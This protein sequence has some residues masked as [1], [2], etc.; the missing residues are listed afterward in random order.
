MGH[1][2]QSYFLIKTKN[3]KRILIT[4]AA[5]VALTITGCKNDRGDDTHLDTSTLVV[6]PALPDHTATTT[7]SVVIKTD[8]ASSHD[9]S[10]VTPSNGSA[11]LTANVPRKPATAPSTTTTKKDESPDVRTKKTSRKGRI[12]LAALNNSTDKIEADKEGIYNRAEVMPAYPGGE[13]ALRRFIE[14]QINYPDNAID[15]NVEGT[16][17]VYFAVDEQGKIYSPT[18]VST[19]LGYGLEEEALRVINHMPKWTPGQVKGR[20]VKTRFTLPITYKI[21]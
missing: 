12:I 20:N 7:D 14:G 13:E 2:Y 9:A 6:T 4:A 11:G 19:K 17:R 21:E 10:A 18:V 1:L 8:T 16:V 15:N 3:M 5:V